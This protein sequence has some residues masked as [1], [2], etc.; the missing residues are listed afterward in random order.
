MGLNVKQR[1]SYHQKQINVLMMIEGMKIRLKASYDYAH[2]NSP[3]DG[4]KRK[5]AMQAVIRK[6]ALD[7]LI[8]YYESLCK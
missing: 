4:L 1:I 5:A 7:R 6:A 8:K 2:G 3:F